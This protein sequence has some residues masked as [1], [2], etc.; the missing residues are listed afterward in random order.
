MK[1]D[2]YIDWIESGIKSNPRSFF[3][4]ANMNRNS[5]GYPS[6]MFFESQSARG[7]VKVV[8]WFVEFFH[9]VYVKEG[10]PVSFPTLDTLPDE[11]HESH[12]VSLVQL[13]HTA[14]EEAILGLNEQKGSG[15]VGILPSILR[16]LVS[17]VKVTL[18]LLFNMSL[19]TCIF[20]VVWK[21]S[22][23]VLNF[24]EWR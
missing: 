7:P 18:M 2:M 8:N 12:K 14:V 5:S 17:V 21:E 1:Y 24:Q 22:F 20:P 13:T 6:S 10:E 9:A 15:P 3:K 4:F 19:S 11:E 23:V 16:K